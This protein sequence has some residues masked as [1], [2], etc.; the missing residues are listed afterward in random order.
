MEIAWVLE[1]GSALLHVASSLASLQHPAIHTA[2]IS[3]W[4]Y[5][6]GLSASLPSHLLLPELLY[7]SCT[8]GFT[9]FAKSFSEVV[10]VVSLPGLSSR[11]FL[12]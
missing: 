1:Q 3:P 12:T 7:S 9:A 6:S 2:A 8:G 11:L 10:G 4:G 5:Q